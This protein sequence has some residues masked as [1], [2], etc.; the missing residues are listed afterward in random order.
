MRSRSSRKLVDMQ[1]LPMD[2]RLTEVS[3]LNT[4]DKYASPRQF[5]SLLKAQNYDSSGVITAE[6]SLVTPE[7]R[8]ITLSGGVPSTCGIWRDSPNQMPGVVPIIGARVVE[9]DESANEVIFRNPDGTEFVL[10]VT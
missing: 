3:W 6:F 7:S 2:T 10:I 4:P 9:A 5:S 1:N 8:S